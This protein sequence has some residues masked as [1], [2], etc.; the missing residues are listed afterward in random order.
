MVPFSGNPD[1]Y[2]NYGT[3]PVILDANR[4]SSREDGMEQITIDRA[5]LKA[6]GIL[7]NEEVYYVTVTGEGSAAY[8]MFV[9]VDDFGKTWIDYNIPTSGE[10]KSGS[11]ILYEL[12]TISN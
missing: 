2:V 7:R 10:L 4:W 8:T 11:L 1:M 5:D 6:D 12:I 3:L 9:Q